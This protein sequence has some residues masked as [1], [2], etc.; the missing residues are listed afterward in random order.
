VTTFLGLIG[1]AFF[2][3]AVIAL[4]AAVTWAVVQV[5]PAPGAKKT[6]S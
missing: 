2:I 6:D 1:L 4:A 3:A 5:S